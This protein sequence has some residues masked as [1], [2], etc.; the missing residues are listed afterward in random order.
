MKALVL[1]SGGI[2][3]AACAITMLL[4]GRDVFLL[5]FDYGQ[6]HHREI[7]SALRMARILQK[8]H[9][10]VSVPGLRG[11]PTSSLTNRDVDPAGKHES[12]LPTAY[13]PGRNLVFLSLASSYAVATQCSEIVIG[14][15]RSDHAGFPDCRKDF[16][17]SMGKAVF[18]GTDGKVS[19]IRA[20]LIDASK[21]QIISLL[22]SHP[23]GQNLFDASWS[24]YLGGEAP[25]DQCPACIE[26]ERGIEGYLKN[27]S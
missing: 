16:I 14:V 23:K 25:C 13:L 9:L 24:C 3:S 4:E 15:C 2:D 7:S 22:L 11:L 5:T 17:Q 18:H 20:P 12:G 21:S 10:V 6:R 19:G 27:K 1:L 26:R 8:P